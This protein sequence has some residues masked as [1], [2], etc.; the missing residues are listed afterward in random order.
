M[1]LI[2]ELARLS[3]CNLL[4]LGGLHGALEEMRIDVG[5]VIIRDRGPMKVACVCIET[6]RISCHLCVHYNTIAP[7]VYTYML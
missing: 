6:D 3:T 2:E 4:V 7:C 5:P 1:V